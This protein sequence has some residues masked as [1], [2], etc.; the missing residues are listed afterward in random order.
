MSVAF[1]NKKI[2]IWFYHLF[3]K[4]FT[5]KGKQL[6]LLIH[7]AEAHD[8][9][10]SSKL[11][12]L[13]CSTGRLWSHLHWPPDCRCGHIYSSYRNEC[14]LTETERRISWSHEETYSI[15]GQNTSSKIPTTFW[16]YLGTIWHSN[17][18]RCAWRS[19]ACFGW[20]VTEAAVSWAAPG[21]SCVPV[22]PTGQS[23]ATAV[24]QFGKVL[25]SSIISF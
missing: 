2:Y 22:Q 19:P 17:Y 7:L 18:Q 13:M 9:V 11:K 16:R 1:K 21:T 6:E 14:Q 20:T 3:R 25:L 8:M 4:S 23:V 10:Q 15:L 12:Q 5:Y 24:H